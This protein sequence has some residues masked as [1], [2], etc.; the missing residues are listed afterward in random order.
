AHVELELRTA[1]WRA[2]IAHHEERD[3]DARSA[4]RAIQEAAL[5]I[6][7]D[8][9]D[10]DAPARLRIARALRSETRRLLSLIDTCPEP[11][12]VLPFDLVKAVGPG[13]TCR[14]SSGVEVTV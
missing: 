5:V 13:M 1:Q 4:A 7:E 8:H 11:E 6:A 12:P 10:L 14:R 9:G 2:D 3:H